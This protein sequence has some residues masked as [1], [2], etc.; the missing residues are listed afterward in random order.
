MAY[1]DIGITTRLK[2]YTNSYSNMDAIAKRAASSKIGHNLPRL[3]Q[4]AKTEIMA[5]MMTNIDMPGCCPVPAKKTENLSIS[6]K[7]GN[8]TLKFQW[9]GRR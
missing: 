4:D 3:R 9:R 8:G 5:R 6:A 2:K 7:F 1:A